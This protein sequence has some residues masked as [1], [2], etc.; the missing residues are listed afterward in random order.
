MPRAKNFFRCF[1]V[2]LYFSIAWIHAQNQE[3]SVVLDI[4]NGSV[5]GT[6]LIPQTDTKI[7]I[8]LIIAGSGPTDRNG[9]NMM[10]TNNHL[11]LLAEGLAEKGI[12]SLRYD[13]R[14][15]GKSSFQDFDERD[16]RFEDYSNDALGLLKQL[17]ADTRFSKLVVIGHS[18]GSLLGILACQQIKVDRFISLAGAGQN[19]SAFIKEQLEKQAPSLLEE[20]LPIFD[21]LEQGETVEKVP[22][23]LLSIFRSS[24]Q[25][26]MISWIKYDPKMEISKLEIPILIVHGTTDIQLEVS[27]A[28]LLMEGNPKAQ[29]EIVEGMNHILKI[30]DKEYL[31]NLQTY[32]NPDLPLAN[33]LTDLLSDFILE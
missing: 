24:V 30:A 10:M 28:E 15:V 17:Q 13:K 23:A 11:K 27:E 33:G 31:P 8:A 22:T 20:A 5:K 3:E 26:Y 12:A 6:L 1:F 21:K 29:L 32:S 19:A 14:G 4:E 7:P 9:N 25:P 18:E 2:L 16:L